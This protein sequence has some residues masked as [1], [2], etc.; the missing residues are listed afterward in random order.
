MDAQ[1]NCRHEYILI[2]QRRLKGLER[3]LVATKA[4]L[5]TGFKRGDFN[6]LGEGSYSFCSK[7]RMRL[8]P[9]RTAADREQTR[10]EMAKK[11]KAKEQARLA[12][13]KLPLASEEMSE[14]ETVEI[15]VEELEVE[16]VDIN[17][18]EAEGV[19]LDSDDASCQIDDGDD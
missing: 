17:D 13:S 11:K 12:E 7:C 6:H 15:S 10:L 9:K 5:P 19:K 18:I 2:I 8:H 4:F 14:D 1:E 3:R 16:A